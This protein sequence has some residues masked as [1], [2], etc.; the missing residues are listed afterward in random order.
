MNTDQT[1]YPE[2]CT[3]ELELPGHPLKYI[4]HHTNLNVAER[5]YGHRNHARQGRECRSK[6]LF[7]AADDYTDV[8]IRIL[9][10]FTNITK[11]QLKDEERADIIAGGYHEN[12]LY[13][14][15][16]PWS[17]KG[18]EYEKKRREDPKVKAQCNTN[19]KE[20]RHNTDKGKA[21]YERKNDARRIK[22]FQDVPD[23]DLTWFTHLCK[24][25]DK[26][27]PVSA[28]QKRNT[29]RRYQKKWSMK[30][31]GT[32]LQRIHRVKDPEAD[33]TWFTHLCKSAFLIYPMSAEENANRKRRIKVNWTL[34]KKYGPTHWKNITPHRKKLYDLR[35]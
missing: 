19:K 7:Y 30:K 17:I 18:W 2:A 32:P 35:K 26:Y 27:Y 1:I 31:T 4:G 8:Q 10:T 34:T 33:V 24:N 9:R 22:A 3:Y 14:D 15:R 5:L 16:L 11:A 6:Y 20:W 12:K 29:K 13:N 23:D 28:A 21:E 25:A